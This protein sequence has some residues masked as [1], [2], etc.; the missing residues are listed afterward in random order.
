MVE[1]QN[2]FEEEA[3]DLFHHSELVTGPIVRKINSTKTA[4]ARNLDQGVE[5][6]PKLSRDV[7]NLGK[8]LR[9]F[10]FDS[11]GYLADE[12]ASLSSLRRGAGPIIY[13]RRIS[14]LERISVGSDDST[15]SG[16]SFV[17]P[18]YSS[19]TYIILC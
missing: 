3:T 1:L 11:Q 12:E 15:N 4:S 17:F 16:G 8:S 9:D 19:A 13:S 5:K 6:F 10:L 18:M 7:P 14:S 2:P